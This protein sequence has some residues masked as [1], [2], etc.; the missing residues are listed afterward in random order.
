NTDKNSNLGCVCWPSL[1]ISAARNVQFKPA[2][3][4]SLLRI[5]LA[6]R[7]KVRLLIPRFAASASTSVCG[8]QPLASDL[9]VTWWPVFLGNAGFGL[10]S[11]SGGQLACHGTLGPFSRTRRIRSRFG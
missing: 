6:A 5:R 8:R 2:A 7:L 1:A 3:I 11:A 9:A 10:R 4:S